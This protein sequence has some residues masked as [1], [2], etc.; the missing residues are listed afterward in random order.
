M[1]SSNGNG[2]ELGLSTPSKGTDT[3]A[4]WVCGASPHLLSTCGETI[5][6]GT[7][8]KGSGSIMIL[9]QPVINTSNNPQSSKVHKNW[10]GKTELVYENDL[11]LLSWLCSLFALLDWFSQIN[12]SIN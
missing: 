7:W 6:S 1:L 2:D 3:D 9:I 12:S 10:W 8:P 4:C 5:G 11:K